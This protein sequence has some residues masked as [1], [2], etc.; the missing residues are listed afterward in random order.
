[1]LIGQRSLIVVIENW[2]LSHS[3][4]TENSGETGRKI[5][6]SG[7]TKQAHFLYPREAH[8]ELWEASSD[9][10]YKIKCSDDREEYIEYGQ[11][12]RYER[13]TKNNINSFV[14]GVIGINVKLF[15]NVLFIIKELKIKSIELELKLYGLDLSTE[16]IESDKWPDKKL[17]SITG[18]KFIANQSKSV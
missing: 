18:A 9:I 3:L 17:L 4:F 1:M 5:T 8:I 7:T 6:L 15:E 14:N 13:D 10:V 16:S 12:Q 2:E 11:I